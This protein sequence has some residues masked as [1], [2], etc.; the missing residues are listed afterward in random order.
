VQGPYGLPLD[1]RKTYTKLD[2]V[3]WTATLT[4]DRKDFE[5]L[6]DPVAR[7][8]NETPDRSPMTDWYFTDSAKKRGFTARPVVGGVFLQLLY[9]RA[10]WK[11]YAGRD[12]TRAKAW[13]PM[14]RP[15]VTVPVV[16]TSQD[17]AHAWHYTT[18][19]PPR[20]WYREN[21]DAAEW[22]EG[23]AGFGTRKTPGTVVR[24][25][26]D[27][28]DIWIRRMV[29]LPNPVPERL[30][31]RMHHDEDAEVYLNGVLAARASEYTSDYELTDIL[32]EARRALRPGVNVI[33]IHCRQTQGGQYIDAGLDLIKEAK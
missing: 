28:P 7:F 29:E 12:R 3:L 19:E 13:A 16:A 1:G 30:A 31:L 6:V 18:T 5:A 26:W 2:W 25:V 27:T 24:T 10:V 9:D 32:P 11:K 8:L 14:P 4:Q 21:F 15:P 33:A 22:K 17:K 20:D 23:P